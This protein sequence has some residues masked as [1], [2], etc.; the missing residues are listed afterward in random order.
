MLARVRARGAP[1]IVGTGTNN[2]RSTIAATAALAGTPGGRRR[3][4]RRAVLRAPVGAGDR[5]ALPRGRGREPGSGDRRTT[6]RRAPAAASARRRCSSSRASRTSPASSRP[7]PRSTSTRS[8]CSP[9]RPPASRARRRRHFAVP[10]SCAWAASARSRPP[11]HLC[12]ARFVAMVECGLAGKLEDGRA[13]RRGAA[14]GDPGRLR[15]AESGGVQGRAARAGPDRDPRRAH[16]AHERVGRGDRAL[17]RCGR[18]RVALIRSLDARYGAV[19]SRRAAWF[20]IALCA[21]TLWVW[22]TFIVDHRPPGPPDRAS[23][24]C[25]GSSR[26]ARSRSA[27][28]PGRIGYR[29]L[30]PCR[31]RGPGSATGEIA[32]REAL[33]SR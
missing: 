22:L 10:D 19:M 7:S 26:S 14:A 23:R 5:R 1:L 12:T 16:A 30:R 4:R 25:T 17:P 11:S 21:W 31:P 28:P 8:K 2:T 13:P 6:S 18:A 3:A 15:R 20:L 27:S 29:A 33:R 24:S 32:D 9:T